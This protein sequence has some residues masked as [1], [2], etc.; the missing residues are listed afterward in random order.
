[1]VGVRSA[2]E[3]PGRFRRDAVDTHESGDRVDTAV[4]T[5]GRQLGVDARTAIASFDLGVDRPDL[6]DQDMSSLRACTRRPLP[7][8]VVAS[9]RN[10]ERL[11]E[12]THGPVA[13]MV[14]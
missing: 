6:D 14:I 13:S 2:T 1:M 12:Q 5:P 10:F 11:T 7:P 3:L 4:L 8:G 9:R